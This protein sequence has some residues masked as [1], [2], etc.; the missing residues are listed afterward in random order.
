MFKSVH[1]LST[2]W[3][4]D[5]QRLCVCVCVC[6]RL[7]GSKMS[8]KINSSNLAFGKKWQPYFWT[9]VSLWSASPHSWSD[10]WFAI[11]RILQV[12]YTTSKSSRS[13]APHFSFKQTLPWIT[14]YNNN[15]NND[16]NSLL[17][18]LKQNKMWKP[19]HC[20]RA[21]WN[22]QVKEVDQ[23]SQSTIHRFDLGAKVAQLTGTWIP[24]PCAD[25]PLWH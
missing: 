17:F 3:Q 25:C 12:K 21:V 11:Y 19:P 13:V 22:N 20:C 4:N 6:E 5:T 1:S 23:E 10:C 18:L 15:N 8:H 9:S 7:R 14:Q 24:W 2:D 16:N